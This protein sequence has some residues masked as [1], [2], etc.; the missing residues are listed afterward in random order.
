MLATLKE[1]SQPDPNHRRTSTPSRSP[2][3]SKQA[4]TASD[5]TG[6]ELERAEKPDNEGSGEEDSSDGRETRESSEGTEDEMDEDAVLLKRP[7]GV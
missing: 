6:D 4:I 5:E 1:I 2:T 7:K 3:P